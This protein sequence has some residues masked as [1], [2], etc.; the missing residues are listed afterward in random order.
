MKFFLSVIPPVYTDEHIQSVFTDGMTDRK[1][2]IKKKSGSL[3]WRF[4]RVILP[5]ELP[6]DS[7]RQLRTVT[8]PFHR[9]KC[10]RNYQG[11]Q[12][13]ISVQW[14][15]LF[16]VRIANEL[17]DRIMSLMN[18]SVKVNIC[19]LC[20]PSPPLF[21]LL[22]PHPNSPLLQTTT[23]PKTNLP[24]LNTTSHISWSFVVTASVF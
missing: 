14:C 11:I 12:T 16:T 7:K 10:Q 18:P 13:K 4:L 23:P 3:T 15:A 9:L 22:L 6:R 2:R 24:L 1:F 5:T 17:T 21:L 8:W 19:P 20:R